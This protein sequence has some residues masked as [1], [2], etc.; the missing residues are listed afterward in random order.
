MCISQ[1]Q[2]A[3]KT[4]YFLLRES[5]W[6]GHNRN[7][8]K[9]L[10]TCCTQNLHEDCVNLILEKIDS[11]MYSKKGHMQ[12]NAT[13]KK[14][15]AIVASLLIVSVLVTIGFWKKNNS[16][17][18]LALQV[19][20]STTTPPITIT[21]PTDNT[22]AFALLNEHHQVESRT[23]EGGVFIQ[24]I[25]GIENTDTNAWAVKYQ[26]RY[27]EKSVDA[28]TM[29]QGDTLTVIYVSKNLPLP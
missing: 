23:Y 5:P 6:S 15:I 1:I 24:S 25:N 4:L 29:K 20:S 21:A 7:R 3:Q 22:N 19:D 14:T 28:L 11:N 8:T 26:D 16:P 13:Q 17:D 9:I 27:I 2:Y 18:Q 12:Q 10:A